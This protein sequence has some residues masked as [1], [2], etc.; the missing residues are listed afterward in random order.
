MQSAVETEVKGQPDNLVTAEVLREMTITKETVL[1]RQKA[2]V[3]DSLMSS[4]VRLASENGAKVYK[5]NLNPQFDAVMLTQIIDTLK[6]LGY[7]VE[8]TKTQEE[9]TKQEV[10]LLSISWE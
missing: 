3:L 8:T 5:A 4:M 2:S 7:K 9:N 1:E 10:I 6:G